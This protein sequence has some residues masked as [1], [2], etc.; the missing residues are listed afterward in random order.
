M[1]RSQRIRAFSTLLVLAGGAWVL[2]GCAA[3]RAEPRTAHRHGRWLTREKGKPEGPTN[4]FL[5]QRRSVDGTIPLRA[6]ARALEEHLR[7]VESSPLVPG[8]WVNVGPQ[9]V[10]GRVTALAVDPVSPAHLW[11]GTAAGGVWTSTDSGTSWTSV[12]DDQTALSIGS[13]A[14]HPTDSN[15]VY[16]GTGED[17][18][19]GFSYDGEGIFKTTNGG[20]TWTNAGLQ[21]TRRIGQIA[22]D[23]TDGQRIFVAAGGD[24]FRRDTNRGIYRSVDGAATWQQ[25]LFVADDTGGIDLAIDP[26]NPSRIFAALW[27]RYSEATSWYIG[28][29]SS[30][31]YRSEDGGDTW[32][33]LAGGLPA[34]AGRIGLALAPSSPQTVYACVI[35]TLGGLDGVYRSLDSGNSWTRRST[36]SSGFSSYSYYFSQIRVHPTI[37]DTIYALDVNL[38]RSTNGGQTFSAIAGSV[39]V[40]WHALIIE[41][42]G[43]WL[44]GTDGGFYRS[45]N[46]GSAFTKALTLPITQFYDLGISYQNPLVRFAG[47]QDNFT[48]RTTTGGIS[49]WVSVLGGDGLQCEVDY[50]NPSRVYAEYQYGGINRSTNG[51]NSFSSATTGIVSSDRRNWNTPITIDPLVPSTLY[52]GTQRVYRSTDYAASWSPISP[53]LSDGHPLDDGPSQFP[54]GGDLAHLK[55]LVDHTITVVSV[56]KLDNDI[57]WVGTDDGNVWVSEDAGAI[58]TNVNPPGADYWVT[59]IEP[60]RLD[61][62]TAYLTVTGYREGDKLPYVRVT[63]DLGQ[64]WEDLGAGLPQVPVSTILPSSEWRG[65]LFVGNDLGVLLSDDD[66]LTWADM[67]GGMPYAVVMD[68]VEHV[69]SHTLFAGTHARSI[70]TF[71]TSQLPPPDGD[72]DG[73]D[74]NAD[75]AL[76]DAG[77][78][79][80]PEEVGLLQLD[81]NVQIQGFAPSETVVLSWPS[82]ASQA[83][84]GTVY[85]VA[86]GTLAA[87]ATQGT[88]GAGFLACSFAGTGL[89][90]ETPLAPRQGIYYLV[91]GRNSCGAGS[92]GRDGAGAER[93]PSACP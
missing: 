36:G 91:R 68:L 74:N 88:S 30:G 66:G 39:H 13:V 50:A 23:P 72:G 41:P 48:Q 24:W 64:T 56:S 69:P 6:R 11:L 10:G 28:G 53:D 27:Q 83:G 5:N 15:I 1:I 67:R 62:S 73:L 57:L 80:L 18:G 3:R 33:K 49:D 8:S 37:P 38:L 42:G 85:D 81:S 84:G 92:W 75:C 51:G 7:V 12:F 54:D 4:W 47:A 43:R 65:R 76:R 82:L 16:V 93:A 17:N 71:D 9:N 46:D 59:D 79:A 55:N 19:G 34:V 45:V 22:I 32:T 89:V 44:A 21:A 61:A 77:A 20:A 70:F 40:D 52:T 86:M 31:I 14:T 78:I 29:A 87:L 35:N 60:S 90:D 58:W 63:R 2:D 26:T 25:V